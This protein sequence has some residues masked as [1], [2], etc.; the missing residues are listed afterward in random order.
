MEKYGFFSTIRTITHVFFYFHKYMCT[1]LHTYAHMYNW[2]SGSWTVKTGSKRNIYISS[3]SQCSCT[4]CQQHDSGSISFLCVTCLMNGR[5][6]CIQHSRPLVVIEIYDAS[7]YSFLLY[8]YNYYN[9][10][11]NINCNTSSYLY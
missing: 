8:C 10:Y 2:M 11:Y 5:F 7:I 4:S 9:V 3:T 1:C 6:G